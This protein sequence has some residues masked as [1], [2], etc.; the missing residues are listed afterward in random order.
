[1]LDKLTAEDFSP[2]L[3]EQ[4]EINI[5]QDQNIHLQLIEVT[6]GKFTNSSTERKTFSIVFRG[7]LDTEIPQ[8]IYAIKHKKLGELSLFLVPIGPDENGMCFEAVFN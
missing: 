4:F 3:E 2:L 1:M 7:A 8:G 6:P 5:A